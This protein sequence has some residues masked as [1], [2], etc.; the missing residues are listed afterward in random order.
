MQP[1]RLKERKGSPPRPRGHFPV[2][3]LIGMS[4]LLALLMGRSELHGQPAPQVLASYTFEGSAADVSSNSPS[5]TLTNAPF[6]DGALFLN[7][8]FGPN[9]TNGYVALAPVPGLSYDSFTFRLEF[10]PAS[11]TNSFINLVSGGP[12]FRWLG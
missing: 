6:I 1:D 2:R 10:K 12:A 8:I 11:F 7:G 5:L 4:A 9:D 3:F